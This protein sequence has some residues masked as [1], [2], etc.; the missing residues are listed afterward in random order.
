MRT[1]SKRQT[2]WGKHSQLHSTADE[3]WGKG[4]C[5]QV[6]GEIAASAWQIEGGQAG[7]SG[8]HMCS[9]NT[10]NQEGRT[11]VVQ[12]RD[13]CAPASTVPGTPCVLR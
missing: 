2:S 8:P 5:E 11:Q 12:G 9:D 13:N 6:A 3:S 7:E 10:R 4:T 1:A